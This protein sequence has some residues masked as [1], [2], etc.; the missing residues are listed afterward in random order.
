MEN[1]PTTLNVNEVW[2]KNE[3]AQK[4]NK[5]ESR[6]THHKLWGR[7]KTCFPRRSTASRQI[8]AAVL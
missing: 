3:S 1:Q 6:S 2:P 5:L 4:R 8:W 7:V